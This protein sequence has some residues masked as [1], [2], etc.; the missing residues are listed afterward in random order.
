MNVLDSIGV[1]FSEP[2]NLDRVRPVGG[3]PTSAIVATAQIV[4]ALPIVDD[5]DDWTGSGGD[6]EPLILTTCGGRFALVRYP[7]G[8][9][10]A[11][12][13]ISDQ[14]PYGQ[15]EPG[16][17]AW[18]LAEVERLAEPVPCKGRQGVW[19]LPDDVAEAVN[20]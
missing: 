11:G 1:R 12:D 6:T 14:I 20:R 8:A 10:W 18:E 2:D 7:D 16:G 4:D 5:P 19:R 9:G 15:W 13:D 17:W 3:L